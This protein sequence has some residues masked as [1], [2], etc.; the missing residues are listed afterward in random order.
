MQDLGRMFAVS[1]GPLSLGKV[2]VEFFVMISASGSCRTSLRK[3][4]VC[5]SL[6][7]DSCQDLCAKIQGHLRCGSLAQDLCVRISAI[8]PLVQDVRVRVPASES[9][10]Y[11]E[12]PFPDYDF[13]CIP[14]DRSQKIALEIP[15]TTLYQDYS[16]RWTRTNS[17]DLEIRK[18]NFTSMCQ[19][20]GQSTRTITQKVSLR[21]HGTQL[22]QHTAHSTRTHDPHK[23]LHL[24]FRKQHFTNI[25]L[26]DG[27]A[28]S[29]Q[30]VALEIKKRNCTSIPGDQHARSPQ[31]AAP[32][33]NQ[34][35]QL[36]Q[37]SAHPT[38]TISAKGSSLKTILQHTACHEMMTRNH[39]KYCTG[40]TTCKN[41]FK[42]KTVR[43]PCACH[44]KLNPSHDT[45]LP[46]LWQ[47]P[48]NAAPPKMFTT[49]PIPR[50]CHLSSRFGPPQLKISLHLPRKTEGC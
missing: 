18:R 47:R 13:P 27:H 40:H 42:L 44:A 31:K 34:K 24:K 48:R 35:T 45:R 25:I 12:D 22:C 2:S 37:H 16:A 19:H 23:G 20:S 43:I 32:L 8:G 38:C 15:K 17:A 14:R 3:I 46:T 1:V 30:R 11:V 7:Q 36:Y 41:M 6:G 21:N 5:E 10:I 29:P 26:R 9:Y 33:R 49:C 28:R 50:T 4:C 39:T